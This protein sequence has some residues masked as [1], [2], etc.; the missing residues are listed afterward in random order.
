MFLV[1]RARWSSVRQHPH[2]GR[3]PLLRGGGA[4]GRVPRAGAPGARPRTPAD[5]AATETAHPQSA[6]GPAG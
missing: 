5:R 4:L 2:H 6:A 1:F 3:A